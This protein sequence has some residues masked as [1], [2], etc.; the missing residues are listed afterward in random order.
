ML[1]LVAVLLGCAVFLC[2]TAAWGQGEEAAC[3]QG[4]TGSAKDS[5]FETEGPFAGN[6]ETELQR[7]APATAT[8]GSHMNNTA[9]A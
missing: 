4:E 8:S 6:P 7:R 2:C 5:K 1:C 9:Q 3:K